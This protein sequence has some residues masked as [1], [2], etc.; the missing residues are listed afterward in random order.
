MFRLRS[1]GV[2]YVTPAG[3][4]SGLR[5]VALDVARTGV[6][7]LAGPSGSGKSTLLRLLGLVERPTTGTV[8]FDGT[9][10]ASLSHQRRRELRRR[11]LSLVFQNPLDNLLP[12][13]S[14]GENLHAAAESSDRDCVPEEILA[15]LGLDGTAAWRIGAL[16]GGQQQRLAFGCVLA[17]GTD[18]VL[19]DEPTSQLDSASADLVLDTL[20]RLAGRG[21]TVVV[22]SHDP[23]LIALGTHVV[24]LRDGA[25]DDGPVDGGGPDA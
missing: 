3:P 18:V 12:A 14:V 19:S 24:R 15:D 5:D 20:R 25:V 2:E 23:E 16:S 6:T 1:V 11:R 9:D 4:V 21:L 7:V 17:R 8:A 10:V 13:L 22:T